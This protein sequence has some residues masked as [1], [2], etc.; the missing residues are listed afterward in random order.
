MNLFLRFMI[1]LLSALR[2]PI[3]SDP[4]APTRVTVPVWRLDQA[5]APAVPLHR[6]RSFTDLATINSV[7]R[8]G[9]GRLIRK[10][11]WMP[12]IQVETISLSGELRCPAKV[13]IVTRI[14]GWQDNYV[15]YTHDINME[16]ETV[17]V[18]R[19]LARIIGRK[20][21]KIGIDGIARE[22]GAPAESPRL[23]ASF[24]AMIAESETGRA[25]AGSAHDAA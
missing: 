24:V 6:I 1:V 4:L 9:L 18:S 23:D 20:G 17:A 15:C 22:L 11:G 25:L 5:F 3:A 21:V 10:N 7:I 14:V 8:I 13:E 2:S 12:I 19:M 16:G